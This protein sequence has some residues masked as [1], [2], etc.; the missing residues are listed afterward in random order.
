MPISNDLLAMK[1][2]LTLRKL[3]L[4]QWMDILA[5]V[6]FCGIVSC[7]QESRK[8]T[9]ITESMI[10]IPAGKF[11]L[12]VGEQVREMSLPAYFIDKTEVTNNAF[13]KFILS[14]GYETKKYWT[15]AGW[16]FIKENSIIH[17][18]SLSRGSFNEPE[19]PVAGISWYEADA[20]CRWAGKRLPTAE[21]WEKAARGTDGRLFPW[22]N[23]M[24]Y[25]LL[26]YRS[27]NVH[28]PVAVG[29]FPAGGSPYGV[30]D[31]AGNVWEWTSSSY[32]GVDYK[33]TILNPEEIEKR[34][35]LII[36]KGGS[37]GSNS[38]QFQCG[39]QYYEQK[40]A[41]QFNIGFRC[42]SD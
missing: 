1:R 22:G 38:N 14:G 8:E 36:I 41:T 31:M 3:T 13:E 29:L 27:S 2:R 12:G 24:D 25:S 19:K 9:S 40:D 28:R 10:N 7:A 4:T 34:G 23:R 30:L 32:E 5:V 17:P 26:A 6:V 37:W 15:A 42:V 20:Y 39:Y 33:Y 16:N 21:E 18:K 11:T 35:E